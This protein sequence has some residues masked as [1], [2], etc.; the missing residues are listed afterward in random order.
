MGHVDRL[1]DF[2]RSMLT[3]RD[4][5]LIPLREELALLHT[6]FALEQERFGAAVD[7]AV[8]LP[9]DVM[10]HRMVPLTLQLLVENVLKHNAATSGRPLRV[11]VSL[12]GGMVEV[13]NLRS[14]RITASRSTSFGLQSIRQ[15]YADLDPRPVEVEVSNERFLVRIPLIGPLE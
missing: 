13:A 5:E 14:P 11:E 9:E 4:K 6:Y 7:L 3:L 15:R 10:L 8:D 12:K 2:F 1:S